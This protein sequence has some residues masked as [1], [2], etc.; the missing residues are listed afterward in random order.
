MKIYKIRNKDTGLFSKGGMTPYWSKKGKTWNS[1]GH[2][3][4]HLS[5]MVKIDYY[6]KQ[7]TYRAKDLDKWEIIEIE[8]VETSKPLCDA[9]VLIQQKFDEEKEKQRQAIEAKKQK[10][11]IRQEALCKLTDVERKAL[12]L[13]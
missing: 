11:R 1:F 6:T 12:G 4:L 8:V 10:D 3:K 9:L 7:V 13:S 5:Q 2:L